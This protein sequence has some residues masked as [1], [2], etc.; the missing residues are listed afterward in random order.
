MDHKFHGGPDA[1]NTWVD[2]NVRWSTHHTRC[3]RIYNIAT[4]RFDPILRV[5]AVGDENNVPRASLQH[6][7]IIWTIVDGTHHRQLQRKWD[8]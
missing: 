1:K 4:V 3:R 8:E 6:V 2:A 5:Y 7:H